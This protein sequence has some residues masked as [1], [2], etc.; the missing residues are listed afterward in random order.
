[1]RLGGRGEAPR[2]PSAGGADAGSLWRGLRGACVLGAL[3][4]VSVAAGQTAAPRSSTGPK[5][6]AGK[7][8]PARPG[9]STGTA[10]GATGATGAGRTPLA[11]PQNP[12]FVDCDK[13][14]MEGSTQRFVCTGHVKMVR[15]T[16]TLTCDRSIGHYLGKDATEITRLE[17]FGNVEAVDGE[18]WARGDHADYDTVKEVL[19]LTGNPEA[20]QGTNTMKGDRV[21]FYVDTDLIEVERVKGVLESKGK[22]PGQ[23]KATPAA[24]T[25]AP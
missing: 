12:V 18:R 20:R 11:T 23:K 7:S 25:K 10:P 4:G 13:G 16:T 9:A 8:A 17:C 6:A 15:N 5:P 19:V 14:R 22:E 1:M 3:L 2:S 21:V 24:P